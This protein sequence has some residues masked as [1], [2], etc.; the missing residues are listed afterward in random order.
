MP[1]LV[2]FKSTVF[3]LFL[4]LI[5]C[6]GSKIEEKDPQQDNELKVGANRADLYLPLLQ[7]KKVAVVANQT[8]VVLN[9]KGGTHLVD[10]LLSQNIELVKIFSPEHGFRGEADAGETVLDGRDTKTGLPLISLYGKNKKPSQEQLKGVDLV[11][12]DIQDVGVRF[13]TYIAT[14]QYVMEACAE[15]KGSR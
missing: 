13:Y 14:L 5:S 8:S 7:G 12:F 10:S 3:V 6:P 2:H 9:K 4:L 15:A 11:I 1:N